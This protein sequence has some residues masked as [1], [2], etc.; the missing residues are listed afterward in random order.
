MSSSGT[1]TPCT[2][3]GAER[4]DDGIDNDC[5]MATDCEDPACQAGFV[6]IPAIPSG[7][8][9]V[10]FSAQDRSACPA[11]YATAADVVSAPA[12]AT[13]GC[14]CTEQKAASCS[15]GTVGLASN[16][17]GPCPASPTFSLEANGS[18]CGATGLNTVPN[19]TVKIA[20][21]PPKQGTCSGSPKNTI[22]PPVEGR[23]CDAAAVG[24]G[25][26]H[27]G[28]CV[29]NPS[30]PFV[31]CIAHDGV[32]PCP[33]GFPNG[34]AVG[35]SAA[36]T[37][38][39]SSCTCGTSATCSNPKLTLYKDASCSSGAH[40]LPVTS[41]CDPVSDGNGNSYKSFKYTAKIVN[42]GC[43]TTV[44]S[45]PT[46]SLVLAGERTVCCQ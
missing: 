9:A 43:Q 16:G 45:M 38:S 27:G 11:G 10:A 17:A 37:R 34:H 36:D 12:S 32:E 41:G 42:P 2:P 14:T 24:A 8:S 19:G 28:A 4:C 20:P 13:C 29:T 18:I 21:L 6:C 33:A 46:G 3:T 31:A 39:C 15:E 30:G 1:T 26:A 7:W 23:S 44:N 22:M 40:E 25:C 5:N 35:A